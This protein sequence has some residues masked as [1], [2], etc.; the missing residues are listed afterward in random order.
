MIGVRDGYFWLWLFPASQE[1]YRLTT[2]LFSLAFAGI[3]IIGT[4]FAYLTPKGADLIGP[5]K[6]SLLADQFLQFSLPF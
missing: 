6:S 2:S 5:V 4:V 3:I 1:F